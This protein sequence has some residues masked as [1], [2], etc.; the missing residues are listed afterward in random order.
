MES[1]YEIF[2]VDISKDK[3]SAILDQK[4][5]YEKEVLTEQTILSF[6]AAHHVE[7]GINQ[8]LIKKLVNNEANSLTFPMQIAAGLPAEDGE[9]GQ[10]TYV[11]TQNEIVEHEERRDFRDVKKI[12]S[13]KKGEKIAVISS[14][15]SGKNGRT[16]SDKEV[17]AK[18][19]K[20][21]KIRAGKNVVYS[22]KEQS[23]YAAIDGQLSIGNK[24]IHVF[25]TY[26]LNTDLSLET[27]NLKF[28]GSIVIRGNVPTG[29]RVEAEGD[30]Y[31]YGL[32][33][34][35][36]LEAKG[37]IFISEGIAGLRKGTVIANGDVTI[38]YAN[39]AIIDSGKDIIIKNS[40]M[41]S[42]C[43]AK[44]RIICNS[45]HIIGGS[46]SSGKS[47]QVK[48]V[49]NKMSTKTEI[50]I[51]INQKNYELE[52][53]LNKEKQDLADNI[54][55]LH[56]L[57]DKLKAKPSNEMNV[58]ERILLLKQRNSLKQSN[59]KMEQIDAQL[60]TLQVDLGDEEEVRLIV[61][62]T[63][64]PNVELSFGK[65]KKTITVPRKYSQIYLEDGE[66]IIQS[67]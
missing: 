17:Q 47:I 13:L 37:N 59:E 61:K 58:K 5:D 1:L 15:T 9:D 2:K 18:Q 20:P 49:G 52:N 24:V 64:Y 40:I 3:M 27:G 10:I 16:V 56:I 39:Q 22:E 62:G 48:D 43:V 25:D 11:C 23:F 33:E 57:G 35:A 12:P 53:A 36:Y 60:D 65:Y 45:G 8:A 30:I 7:Y 41:H 29:Y 21:V 6:L 4:Q 67:L 32:V 46:C 34:G 51:G 55:K 44:E 31:V 26:E 38:G 63:M 54:K 42:R 66:I 28:V 14:P 19:G 50:S